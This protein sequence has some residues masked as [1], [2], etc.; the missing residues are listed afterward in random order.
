MPILKRSLE[1]DAPAN[2][3]WRVLTTPELVREWA[4]AYQDGLSIRTSWREGEPV[5][6]KTSGGD[7]RAA[8]KVAAYRP[9]KLLKFD[10]A[11]SD[12]HGDF[13][14]T[15]EIVAKENRTWLNVTT[16]PLDEAEINALEGPTEEA[17]KEIKSLAEESA[18]IHGLRRT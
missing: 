5:T 12:D 9:G 16:G 7:T 17:I 13:S 3:V 8:G 1:I 14:D 10:Y 15:Y 4:A 11:S 2:E 6:W 18:Q